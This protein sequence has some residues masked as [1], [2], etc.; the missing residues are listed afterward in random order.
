LKE[1]RQEETKESLE[2][3]NHPS[4]QSLSDAPGHEYLNQNTYSLSKISLDTD[5]SISKTLISVLL[6]LND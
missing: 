1:L 2:E 3:Y 5:I 6:E 4:T